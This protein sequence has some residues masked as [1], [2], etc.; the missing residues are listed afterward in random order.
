MS[1]YD[2][3]KASSSSYVTAQL[4]VFLKEL[5][6]TLLKKLKKYADGDQ[7]Q[8]KVEIRGTGMV[9]VTL[10]IHLWDDNWT[11]KPEDFKEVAELMLGDGMAVGP[12][13]MD[14]NIYVAIKDYQL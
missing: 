6:P 13:R 14:P 8:V 11:Y 12:H 9:R 7:C 4:V 5:E 3:R 10:W 1:D 2:R